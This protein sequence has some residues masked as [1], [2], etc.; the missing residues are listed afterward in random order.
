MTLYKRHKF[1]KSI[2][3]MKKNKEIEVSL[4]ILKAR[5]KIMSRSGN[6]P[7]SASSQGPEH[8]Q[9]C[10]GGDPAAVSMCTTR[11]ELAQGSS[12]SYCILSAVTWESSL[13]TGAV[14]V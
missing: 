1:V 11:P 7:L 5:V 3:K 12:Q 4:S 14:T 13:L 10:T 9:Q 8:C 6:F 2:K